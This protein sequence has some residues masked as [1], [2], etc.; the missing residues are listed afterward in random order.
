MLK[1]APYLL[2]ILR[3]KGPTLF[4]TYLKVARTDILI[5]LDPY[6]I[7]LGGLYDLVGKLSI[8]LGKRELSLYRNLNVPVYW[9]ILA[10]N[11]GIIQTQR[12]IY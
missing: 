1:T 2:K 8:F 12:L 5:G 10:S 7:W 6:K 3:E 9:Y 4:F 11:N